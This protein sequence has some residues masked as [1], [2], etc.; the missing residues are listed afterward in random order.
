MNVIAW[1]TPDF[2]DRSGIIGLLGECLKV[3]R[4][5]KVAS[6]RLLVR[7]GVDALTS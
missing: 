2:W 4:D 7:E 3:E 1:Y 5:K 6:E